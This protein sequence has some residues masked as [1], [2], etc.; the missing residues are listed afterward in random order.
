MTLLLG[1]GCWPIGWSVGFLEHPYEEVVSASASRD[2]TRIARIEELDTTL[3]D[4]LL[5]LA[6][7]QMPA[8]RALV[9]PVGDR[10]TAHITNSCDG[11]DSASWVGHLSRQFG[12]HG[13]IATHVPVGQ[14]VYPCTQF[15][16]LG[17][18]GSP[19][20]YYMRMVAVG[21]AHRGKWLFELAGEQLPFEEPAAY[22]HHQT[23]QRFTRPML[24]RY[25]AA[26]GICADDAS[27]YGARGT[28]FDS[29]S[30]DTPRTMTLAA[31]RAAYATQIVRGG[32]GS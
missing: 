13:V 2:W 16:L 32:C 14:H 4:R 1:G 19:P 22:E 29:Q 25:L 30:D 20:L 26:L 5:K 23:S 24:I 21:V 12:C 3:S 27:A 28:L 11:G 18:A 10:W 8:R 31:A 7:L 15:A 17:P 9:L 6:P